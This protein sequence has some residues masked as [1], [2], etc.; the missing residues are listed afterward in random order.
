MYS[1]FTVSDVIIRR[2]LNRVRRARNMPNLR[3]LTELPKGRARR[4]KHDDI[5]AMVIVS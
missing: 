5:T 1:A 4:S 3:S 2:V